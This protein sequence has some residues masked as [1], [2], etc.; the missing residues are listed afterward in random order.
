[1]CGVRT[2]LLYFK[3]ALR[4]PFYVSFVTVVVATGGGSGSGAGAGGYSTRLL[5][6]LAA[7]V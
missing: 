3:V 2:L 7:L 6:Y 1:M 4:T 5:G